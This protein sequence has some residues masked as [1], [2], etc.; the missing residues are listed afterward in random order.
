MDTKF[1]TSAFS[2]L[3]FTTG[4]T[5]A[6]AQHDGERRVRI[7]ITSCSTCAACAMEACSTT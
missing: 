5:I 7:D 2:V 4:S 6:T 1:L 3:L